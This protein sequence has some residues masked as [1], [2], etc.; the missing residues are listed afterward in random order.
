MV[1]ASMRSLRPTAARAAILCALTGGVVAA[2]M[3]DPAFALSMVPLVLL[4]AALTVG[5]YPGERTIARLR[6][7]RYRPPAFARPA[8]AAV[9]PLTLF[10]RPVGHAF[11]FALAVRPPPVLIARR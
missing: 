7:A 8:N 11:A 4:V 2:G 5:W 3:T 9:R 10:V 6:A 1:R